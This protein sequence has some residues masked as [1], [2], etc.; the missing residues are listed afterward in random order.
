MYTQMGPS[1]EYLANYVARL[2]VEISQPCCIVLYRKTPFYKPVR[3]KGLKHQQVPVIAL[4]Q[5]HV[6]Y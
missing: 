3:D 5:N 4:E 6:Y 2:W 1:G